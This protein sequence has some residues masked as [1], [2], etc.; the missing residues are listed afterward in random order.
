MSFVIFV[1]T[2]NTTTAVNLESV[3]WKIVNVSINNGVTL[4]KDPAQVEIERLMKL[5]FIRY[6]V[7]EGMDGIT[8]TPY[9]MATLSFFEAIRKTAKPKN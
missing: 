5:G 9:G 6:T 2:T 1:I 8:L 7:F 3:T 4:S